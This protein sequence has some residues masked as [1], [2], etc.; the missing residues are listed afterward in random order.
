MGSKGFIIVARLLKTLIPH[1]PFWTSRLSG[2]AL[3]TA[4]PGMTAD[5]GS[6]GSFYWTS[7]HL[8][9]I[10]LLHPVLLGLVWIVPV[11]R[12]S[13]HA[14]SVSSDTR[15]RGLMVPPMALWGIWCI[16]D[17]AVVLQTPSR[18]ATSLAVSQ[19]IFHRIPTIQKSTIIT[20]GNPHTI[21]W[22]FLLSLQEA[23]YSLFLFSVCK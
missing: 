11:D 12:F 21:R 16:R 15:M 18:S 20:I 22:K 14:S 6:H 8:R 5:C 4:V 17:R 13:I 9:F 19:I 23:K 7:S 1:S 10:F 3:P 2:T